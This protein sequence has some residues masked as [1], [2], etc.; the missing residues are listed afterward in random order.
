MWKELQI[1]IF[2][3]SNYD[4]FLLITFVVQIADINYYETGKIAN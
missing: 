3:N 2:N 1:A 4:K